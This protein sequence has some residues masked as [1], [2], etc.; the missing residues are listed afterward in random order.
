[1]AKMFL[2]CPC[3]LSLGCLHPKMFYKGPKSPSILVIGAMPSYQDDHSGKLF[4]GYNGKIIRKLLVKNK[5]DLKTVGWS[6]VISCY[7]GVKPQNYHYD[8]CIKELKRLLQEKAGSIK[9]IFLVGDVPLRKVLGKVGLTQRRGEILKIG[10]AYCVPI[11]EPKD[12]RNSK[13]K[14]KALEFDIQRGVL[15]TQTTTTKIKYQMVN[16]EQL[17]QLIPEI[18]KAKKLTFDTETTGLDSY[19]DQFYTIGIGFCWDGFHNSGVFLPLE[20]PELNITAEE[21][22]NRIEILKEVLALS[23]PKEAYY[24]EYDL[25]VLAVSLGIDLYGIVNYCKDPSHAHHLIDCN[26]TITLSN[27]TLERLPDLAGYDSEME[28]YKSKYGD[29]YMEKTPLNIIAE[30]CVGDCIATHRIGDMLEDELHNIGSYGL[31]TNLVVPSSKI[32][33]LLSIRGVKIDPVEAKRLQEEYH[34]KIQ[35]VEKEILELPAVKEWEKETGEK[36]SLTSSKQK[37]EMVYDFYGIPEE[38]TKRKDDKG[39]VTWSRSLDRKSMRTILGYKGGDKYC[40]KIMD[41]L[42]KI[43]QFSMLN[44]IETRYTSKWKDHLYPDGLIHARLN[45][46]GTRSGRLSVTNPNLQQMPTR[47]D[48]TDSDL[49]KWLTQ[50]AIKKMLVSKYSDGWLVDVDYS[51]LELRLMG[52]LSGDELMLATYRENGDIHLTTARRKFPQFDN[53]PP[54]I[55]KSLRVK[56]KTINFKGAYSFDLEFLA[57]YPGLSAYVTKIKNLALTQGYVAD[58]F[59]R[60]RVIENLNLKVPNKKIYAMSDSER[61]NYF[62]RESALR[63]AVNHTVQGLGHELIEDSLIRIDKKLHDLKIGEIVMETH[64]SLTADVEFEQNIPIVAKIMKEEMEN[65]ADRYDFITIPLVADIEVGRNWWDMKKLV[66]D[67]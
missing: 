13:V 3:E 45:N 50:N 24:G 29:G 16:A 8:P 2:R 23:L 44:T 15:A 53:Q 42:E 17:K 59:G 49:A 65:V 41:F 5:V 28:V 22:K 39:K 67:G 64:D 26:R 14:Y 34:K 66:L 55:Q 48:T 47:I 31:Y 43:E 33:T 46:R 21:Y 37:M 6:N 18:K 9:L 52:M 19:T 54:K 51:Q 20:H 27:L 38:R 60:R 57:L 12:C 7:S 25:K 32:Y 61:E 58:L 4:T 11:Y 30:Y 62:I 36:L 1:M 63:A 40:G 10:N 56:A 35:I